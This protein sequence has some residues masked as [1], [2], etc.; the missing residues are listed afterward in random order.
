[1]LSM[2]RKRLTFANVAMTLALV[3]AMTGGA[4]AAKKYLITNTKQISPRCSSS[5]RAPRGRP[6]AVAG[7]Q[8]AAG[9]DG[10]AGAPGKDGLA[11]ARRQR[12]RG[13]DRRGFAGDSE[14]EGGPCTEQGGS[15]FKSAKRYNVHVQRRDLDGRRH[16]A[17][18]QDPDR[19]C[20]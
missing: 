1:M 3:F 15:A 2:I 13:R 7:L 17:L 14:P 18:W 19:R 10:L 11:G 4:Y 9:K 12:R 8:G 20:K 6:A 16:A 5:S